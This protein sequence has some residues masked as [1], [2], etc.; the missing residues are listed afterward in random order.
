MPLSPGARLGSFEILSVLGAGGMGEVYR[1]KDSRLNREVAI[2]I[3]PAEFSSNEDRLRRFEQ[4]ARSASALNHPNIITIYEI[5]SSNSTAFIAMEYIDG[6]TLRELLGSGPLPG[7][8]AIQIATQIAEGLAKAHEAGIVHRDLKPE[9]I[10][11]TRDGY[12]KILDFGL[13]KALLQPANQQVSVLPTAAGTDAGTVLGTV[14]YMSPE[15]ASGQVIDFRSDQFSFG[16]ILY[17]MVTGKRAFHKKTS[18]ETLAAIIN[19]E[20]EPIHSPITPVAAPIRWIIEGCLQKDPQDRY[21]STRD[22]GRDLQNI[23]DHFSDVS[24]T[25]DTTFEPRPTIPGRKKFHKIWDIAA[26][27]LI[28]ALLSILIFKWRA[29]IKSEQHTR[30]SS[31]RLSYRRGTIHSARFSPDGQTIVYGAS[32]EGQPSDLFITRPDAIESRSLG[33]GDAEI[34]SISPSGE[35]LLGL[36]R[37]MKYVL[38][39]SPLSGGTPR[40]IVEDVRAADWSPDGSKMAIARMEQGETILEYPAGH[41]IFET[42]ADLTWLRFSPDGKY[43]SACLHNFGGSNGK[44]IILD[45]NGKLVSTSGE[46]YPNGLAWAPSSN[47]VWF[48]T[49]SSEAGGGNELQSLDLLNHLK[50]VQ[51]SPAMML[52]DRSKDSRLLTKIEDSRAIASVIKKGEERETNLTWLDQSEV[53]DFSSDGKKILIH[54]RGEG[55]ESP[56]GTIYMMNCDGTSGL[57]LAGGNTTEFSPDGKS[58]LGTVASRQ[59]IQVPVGVGSIRTLKTFGT[60]ENVEAEGF[61]PDG[62]ILLNMNSQPQQLSIFNPRDGQSQKLTDRYFAMRRRKVSPDGKSI[63]VYSPDLQYFVF[64]LVDQKAEPIQGLE[65]GEEPIRW[66]RDGASIFVCNPL[67]LPAKVYKVE[68]SSGKRELF[69]EIHPGDTAGVRSL[70]SIIISD[71]EQLIAYSYGRRLSTLYTIAGMK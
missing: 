2:K 1:G 39:Q 54:E 68:L 71:D 69:R 8:R 34:W 66:T 55:S 61:L 24:V 22:L 7:R 5:G 56:S 47:E 59:V 58:V 70:G 35:M 50:Y 51:P 29:P 45:L 15:Q 3:L 4:E 43:L 20:P 62:R 63:L 40:E 64:S 18:V 38:A 17:E 52:F 30:V 44:V 65:P 16:T 33:I 48:T 9:N 14:G 19:Q 57:R 28:V 53:A 21:A 26:A 12:V 31:H 27:V 41:R 36:Q 67:E 60:N 46:S 13:A 32:W 11:V 37:G 23:R 10:M 25:T 42:T 49:I 6:K